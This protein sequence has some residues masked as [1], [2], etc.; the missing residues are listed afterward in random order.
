MHTGR[1]LEKWRCEHREAE[2]LPPLSGVSR[3]ARRICK[4]ERTAQLRTCISRPG[5]CLY[6]QGS[7]LH[8]RGG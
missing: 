7:F 8:P 3:D 2:A 1:V 5:F 6:S 4:V